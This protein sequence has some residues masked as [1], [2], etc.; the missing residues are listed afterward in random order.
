MLKNPFL[1]RVVKFR[2]KINETALLLRS[3]P[4]APLVCLLLVVVCALF[5]ERLAPYNPIKMQLA[6]AFV[7][8][9]WQHGGSW[10]HLLGTDQFGRDILSRI[11][12]GCRVSLLVGV[13]A[14]GLAGLIGSSLALISGYFGGV[15][16]SIIMRLTDMMLALPWFVLAIALAGVLGPSLQNVIIILASVYWAQYARV[17]RGEVLRLRDADFVQLAKVAGC[18]NFRI[19]R[20]HIFP[21]VINTL[22]VLFTLHL[23]TAVV[24]EAGLTFLGMGVPPPHPAWGLMLSDGRSYLSNAWWICAF[25]GIAIMLVVLSA[26]VMG[27]WLR[28]RLDP[29]LRQAR[30]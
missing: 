29:K 21:N 17:I 20:K 5:A 3:I 13:T 9:P 25:P 1:L 11:I 30:R 12:F 2:L 24:A 8:P 7:P 10:N 6:N 18:G 27:D 26:N 28:I 23:G 15:L 14:V 4:I 22:T 16:D 19:L